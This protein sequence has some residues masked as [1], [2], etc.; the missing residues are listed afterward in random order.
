MRFT[1]TAIFAIFGASAQADVPRVVADI[2]PVHSLVARVMKG[3]GSPDL[4]IQAGASPHSY[5]LR[6][7]E[8]AALER[9]DLVFWIGHGLTPWMEKPLE[10]LAGDARRVELMEVEDTIKLPAREEAI[11]DDHTH[12]H[13]HGQIDPHGWLDPING[14][15]WLDTIARELAKF[16]PENA[17]IYH[18]NAAEGKSE[19]AVSISETASILEPMKDVSLAVFHDAFQYFATRFELKIKASL[20][21]SDA[22]APG[23]A[24]IVALQKYLR[25]EEITCL[26]AEPQ[27]DQSFADLVLDGT[28]AKT[29]VLDP[30][31]AAIEPGPGLYAALIAVMAAGVAECIQ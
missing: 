9:A 8:A 25:S 21:A 15:L 4:F 1:L 19:I 10:T 23:P 22:Q 11:F 24:R 2:P 31:G 28:E 5:S 30:L 3:L 26:I 6:P 13:D 14:Q 29:V 20:F 12:D 16:D 27:F 17:D 18:A 7:S